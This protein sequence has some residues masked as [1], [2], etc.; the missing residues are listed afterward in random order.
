MK[1]RRAGAALTALG[2]IGLGALAVRAETPAG[3]AQAP[4]QTQPPPEA[5]S[6]AKTQP[7]AKAQAPQETQPPPQTTAVK[8]DIP[9][10]IVGRWLFV[11]Q[12]KPTGPV[13]I[14]RLVEIRKGAN[15]LEVDWGPGE[16]PKG[17]QEKCTAVGAGKTWVP[18]QADLD[19]LARRWNDVEPSI[20]DHVKIENQL[21]VKEQYPL[22]FKSEPS[23]EDTTFA[24][25]SRESFS[26]ARRVSTSFTIFGVKERAPGRLT[27]PMVSIS[28]AM[29][30]FPIPIAVKGDYVAYPVAATPEPTFW[31][32]LMSIF[33]GCGRRE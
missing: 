13:P 27:G 25:V 16:L 21:V 31:E 3:T 10:D 33:S 18:T 23:L 14:P 5:E 15:G 19:E 32:R 8:G 12:I 9:T 30:M 11:G 7:P 1:I 6:P 2:I 29:G 28:V 22:E 26:G 20:T 4:P 24:I 17:L